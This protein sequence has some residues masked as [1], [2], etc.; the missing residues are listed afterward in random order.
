MDATVDAIVRVSGSALSI[1][2][3]GVGPGVRVRAD[4]LAPS[5]LPRKTELR[6]PQA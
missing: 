4:T 1:I 5:S 3:V 2:I 6:P